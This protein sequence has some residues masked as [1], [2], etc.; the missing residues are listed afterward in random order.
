MFYVKQTARLM[1]A[2]CVFLTPLAS[3]AQSSVTLYGSL[4]A[5]IQYRSKAD[6]KRSA[7]NLQ[8]YGNLPTLF[9]LTGKED[10]GGGLAAIFKL[11]Q[12]FN[13][14]D[15]T[16]TVPGSAFYRNAYVGL[17]G[18][19]GTVTAGRQTTVLFDDTLEFDP[20]Y[21]AAYS[22]QSQ[23]I[24]ITDNYVSSSIKYQSPLLAGVTM[25]A[26]VATGGVAGNFRSGRV[27][28]LG[29]LYR[30]TALSASAVLR[31][32]N[33]SA[34]NGTPDTSALKRTI[35][36]LDAAYRMGPATILAGV[37]RQTGDLAPSK[38][39]VWGGGRFQASPAIA[40]GLGVYQTLS[41]DPS[42]GHP[43]LFVAGATYSLSKRT[44]AY[45]NVGYSK[46]STHSSQTVYEYDST[47]LN[48]ANQV[49]VMLGMSHS[50]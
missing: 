2:A 24:P 12:S 19:F 11:E 27:L 42:T 38:T 45:L 29:A 16:S 25:K 44:S 9:G 22:G 37:E 18:S 13:L 10:L 3:F 7:V 49:G 8:N 41:S 5:G 32:T 48:G 36:V 23:L 15:G 20:F 50:F 17:S 30:G 1:A 21:Y 35:G 47:P 26:L 4:D 6:G 43:T 31:E 14:N 34:A 40:L 33:G 39:V 46:N 28:E